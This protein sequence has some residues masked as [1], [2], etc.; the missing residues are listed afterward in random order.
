MIT[1]GCMSRVNSLRNMQQI[2]AIL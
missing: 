1:N 2:L